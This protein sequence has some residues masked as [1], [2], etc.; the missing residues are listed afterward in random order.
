MSQDSLADIQAKII[1]LGAINL[2]APE[3]IAAESKEKKSLMFNT[4][5]LLKL[6]K[7][8]QAP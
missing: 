2:A 5:I 7:N 1:R 3:E 6:L 4:T 8:L